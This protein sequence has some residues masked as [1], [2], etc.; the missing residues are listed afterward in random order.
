[1]NFGIVCEFNPF[2]NGHAYLFESAH[3][4]GADNIVCAMSGNAVQRG[5]LAVADKYIRAEATVK[6]GADLVVEIPYPWSAASAEFFALA[7]IRILG[8]YCDSVIF[9]S[10]CGDINLLKEAASFSLSGDFAEKFERRKKS[11]EGAASA[12]FSL[13]SES[14]GRE[15]SSNDILGVEYIKAAEKSGI[16][17]DFYTVARKGSAYRQNALE[18]LQNPSATALRNEW[19]TGKATFDGY[20]PV[21]AAE[22]FARA[23]E[24]GEITDNVLLERAYLTFFRLSRSEDFSNIA[25]AEG[26][27]ADRICAIARESRDFSEFWDK[28]RTKR[29]TDAK[30]RRAMLFCLTG[31]S[32]DL[33]RGVPEYTYLL[34]ANEKGR[35]ILSNVKKSGGNDGIKLITKPADTLKQSG[36]FEAEER[37][38]AIFSLA[39]ENPSS[40][41]DVYRKSAFILY[42]YSKREKIK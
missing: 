41:C 16:K 8:R 17:L 34:A 20:M 40:L 33:L 2:H 4:M 28:L 11:G 3:S 1:M 13:I 10:E 22:V 37:L 6:C 36:Q 21:Q 24:N 23:F 30:L 38:N 19:Q 25:E 26:G 39:R 9:G 7:G 27:I 35:L 5:E 42:L 29:Y 14:I 12:Y 31:V 32:L 18:P 15:L